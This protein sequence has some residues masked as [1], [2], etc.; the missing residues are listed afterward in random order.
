MPAEAPPPSKAVT[1]LSLAALVLGSPCVGNLLVEF[2]GGGPERT[3]LAGFFM[4]PAALIAT[5]G[6]WYVWGIVASVFLAA[7]GAV[8]TR[9]LE[10]AVQ[11]VPPHPPGLFLLWLVPLVTCGVAGLIYALLYTLPVPG[12]LGRFTLMGLAYGALLHW[13]GKR[14]ILAEMFD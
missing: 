2:G 4:L 6:A 7:K 5:L 11:A 8:T 12:T 14:G 9:S 1:F 13:L 10:G 3:G